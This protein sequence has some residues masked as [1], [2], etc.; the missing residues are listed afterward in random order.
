M[1]EPHEIV[2]GYLLK[3]DVAYPVRRQQNALNKRSEP[4]SFIV[5]LG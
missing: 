3:L 2:H 1:I 4:S 5:N